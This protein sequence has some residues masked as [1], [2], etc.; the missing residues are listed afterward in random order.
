MVVATGWMEPTFVYISLVPQS[1]KGQ[2]RYDV[3]NNASHYIHMPWVCFANIHQIFSFSDLH[4]L[5]AYY[6][7]VSLYF[8]IPEE[9]NIIRMNY[10]EL[11]SDLLFN[12]VSSMPPIDL[13]N[14]HD[15]VLVVLTLYAINYAFMVK[16][17]YLISLIFFLFMA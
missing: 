7:C 14:H 6:F 2:T 11:V 13:L 8:S 1:L 17:Y 12:H 3:P 5:V 4:F 10:N 9:V 15:N 16:L